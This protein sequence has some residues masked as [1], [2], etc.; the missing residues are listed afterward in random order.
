MPE[1]PQTT[2]ILVV[3]DR[4]EMAE[5]VAD[6]VSERGNEAIAVSSS[7]EA[8]NRL[9]SER[10]DARVTDL[11]MPEVD[12]LALTRVSLE[13]DPSRPSHHDDGSW[14]PRHGRTG[15]RRGA[16]HYLTKPFR[17]EALSRL[18]ER[19]LGRS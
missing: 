12:G 19:A 14:H 6:A 7:R 5:R 18:I 8:M 15:E 2:R 3:D 16:Y 4:P 1:S 11:R 9:R 13:L 17:L 10:F